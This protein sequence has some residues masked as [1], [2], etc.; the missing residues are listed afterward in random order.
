MNLP[1]KL[2]IV[3]IIFVPLMVLLFLFPYTQYGIE[4][5]PVTLFNTAIE[6][7]YFLVLILFCI[8]S[9]TDYLDGQIARKQN[10]VTTFGKFLDP[11]ADKLLVNTL[12]LLL[13]SDGSISILV[14][15]IMIS[16]DTLVD[17][18]RFFAASSKKIQAAR[19]LGKLKTV[20]Q[21]IAI[22]LLLLQNAPF[23]WTNIPVDQI[24]LYVATAISVASGID[25][26]IQNKDILLESM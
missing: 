21:M 2:T 9:F 17:A 15:I 10:I 3:R 18:I 12:F 25:Y 6:G 1:N 7:E 19:F 11:I 23:G 8:A 20:T 22:I 14:V 26:F 24:M 13:A 16:R 4:L 5:P